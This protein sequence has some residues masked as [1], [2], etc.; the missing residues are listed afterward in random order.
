MSSTNNSIDR[1]L[2][3]IEAALGIIN[4]DAGIGIGIGGGVDVSD[5]AKDTD[6]NVNVNMTTNVD[7]VHGRVENLCKSIDSQITLSTIASNIQRCNTLA[8][9]LSPSGLLLT[10]CGRDGS[11]SSSSGNGNVNASVYVYRRQEILARYDDLRYALE[12]LASIRDLLLI[13][14]PSLAKELQSKKGVVEGGDGGE[15]VIISNSDKKNGMN[16]NMNMSSSDTTIS[17]DHVASAPILAS[18][19][20]TFASDPKNIQK[21]ESLAT[22][23]VDINDRSTALAQRVDD[24]VDRY[25]SI[26]SAVNERL[27]LMQELQSQEAK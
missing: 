1:R 6:M 7:D 10:S 4:C 22:D 3:Y 18:P 21:L 27:I 11:S 8:N 13:S 16:S 12:Q 20:F 9:Q 19:S 24:M 23:A 14:N 2:R 26:L 5:E 15:D 17:M 25:Y